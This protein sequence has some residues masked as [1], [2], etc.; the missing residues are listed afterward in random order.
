MGRKR[1]GGY[2]RNVERE[3]RRSPCNLYPIKSALLAVTLA[4]VH[5]RMFRVRAINNVRAD[6][7]DRKRTYRET[8]RGKV[9]S[10]ASAVALARRDTALGSR[11]TGDSRSLVDLADRRDSD[12]GPAP[13]N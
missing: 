10:S 4:I 7:R 8:I 13:S 9:L 1:I 5:R 11:L 2:E 12:D 6:Y 3:T